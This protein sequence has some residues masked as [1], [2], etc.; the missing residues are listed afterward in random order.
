VGLAG[1][2]RPHP[3]AVIFDLD[4]CLIDSRNAWRYCIEESIAAAT[5][6]R[7]DA[8]ALVDEYHTRP[9]LDALSILTG[10]RSEAHRCEELCATMFE[11]SAMKKLLVFEGIGMALDGLRGERMELGAISR[12]PHA[13]AVKQVQSTGLDRFVAVVAAGP[14]APAEQVGRCLAFLEAPAEACAFVSGTEG[15]LRLALSLGLAAYRAGWAA[16]SAE[17]I[18]GAIAAPSALRT[19]L[20][21][22][23]AHRPSG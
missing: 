16:G 17:E 22:D 6:R 11:R 9:W 4:R 15:D 23:W 1:G 2:Q 10:D 13:L 20:L 7:P 21:A 8:A 5:G 19:R 18:A 14:W 3:R 12:L